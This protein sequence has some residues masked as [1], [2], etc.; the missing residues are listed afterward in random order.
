M[1][2]PWVV[3]YAAV[4]FR[5]GIAGTFCA[6]LPDCPV[7]LMFSVEK[8]DEVFRRISIGSLW[9]CG[10]R[11]RCGDDCTWGLLD[12]DSRSMEEVLLWSVT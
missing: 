3:I 9:V 4:D 10:G 1:V 7:R 12:V 2:R 6:E 8:P 11:A 5:V